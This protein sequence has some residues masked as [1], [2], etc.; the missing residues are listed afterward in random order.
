M[1]GPET[2]ISGPWPTVLKYAALV[3]CSPSPRPFS[4]DCCVSHDQAHLKPRTTTWRLDLLKGSPNKENLY[5]HI[6]IL[7]IYIFIYLFI[8]LFIYLFIYLVIYL[9]IYLCIYVIYYIYILFYTIYIYIHIMYYIYILSLR[10]T[11]TQML[12]IT[13]IQIRYA[14]Y[15]HTFPVASQMNPNIWHW[16]I[17]GRKPKLVQFQTLALPNRLQDERPRFREW[18]WTKDTQAAPKREPLQFTTNYHEIIT[19]VGYRSNHWTTPHGG[20]LSHG[21][22]PQI[23]QVLDAHDSTYIVLKQPWWLGD[24]PSLKKPQYITGF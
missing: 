10:A 1:S 23:I 8:H 16:T 14:V 20:F 24:P 22:S 12:F 3:G 6:C 13:H 9:C 7:H 19:M 5:M 21:G 2:Y 18:T 17:T 11:Y 15:V 4:W